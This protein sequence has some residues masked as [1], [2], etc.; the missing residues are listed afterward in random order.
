[1]AER[2]ESD[3]VRRLALVQQLEVAAAAVSTELLR[4]P[5]W[6]KEAQNRP[7]TDTPDGTTAG[8]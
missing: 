7:P 1:M 4:V 3:A 8:K 2:R 6:P 5:F